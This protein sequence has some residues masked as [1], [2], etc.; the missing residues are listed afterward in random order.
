MIHI[1]DFKILL[2]RLYDRSNYFDNIDP[3]INCSNMTLTSVNIAKDKVRLSCRIFGVPSS[4]IILHWYRK[5][6]NKTEIDQSDDGDCTNW[7]KTSTITVDRSNKDEEVIC[8]AKNKLID[9][10]NGTCYRNRR[11][12]G[13]NQDNNMGKH[14]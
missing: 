12:E 1:Y 10:V 13:I 6:D 3:D 9:L 4:S 14:I 11:I 7:S 5:G 8:E 2:I